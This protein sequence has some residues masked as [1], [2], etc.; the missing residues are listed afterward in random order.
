MG[1][2]VKTTGLLGGGGGGIT[3]PP[4]VYGERGHCPRIM[5]KSVNA[6]RTVL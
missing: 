3:M 5:G 1:K 6:K 2:V 4:K